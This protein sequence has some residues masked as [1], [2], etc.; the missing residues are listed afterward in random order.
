MNL[1]LIF[2][3]ILVGFLIGLS[4]TAIG[5]IGMV[6]AAL[7]A[8][9]IPAK[10]STGVML[11]LL[12]TGDLFAIGIYKKH[13]EWKLLQKLIWPVIVGI[14][15]GVYF[16]AHSTDTSLKRTIGWIVLLLVAF[17]PISQRLKKGQVDISLRYP[18]PLRMV[19]GSMAGFMSMVAN[20]GGPPM[21]IYLLLK[22]NNVMN[23]LGNTAWFFF[24]VNIFK[25]PFTL[26]LGLLNFHSFYYILPA[27]PAVPIG[28][29]VGRRIISKINLEIFQRLTLVT[30]AIA[31][32]NLIIR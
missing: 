11:V 2:L 26:G 8:S 14:L 13:V 32:L 10:E 25:L 16:L 12:I 21:S 29:L 5:G 22:G 4:K 24:L 6:N 28:A 31:G 7:L 20:S 23:F 30:A 18:K 17:Y 9:V 19:L 1:S 27:L 3:L 15:L